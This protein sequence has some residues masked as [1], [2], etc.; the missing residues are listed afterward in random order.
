M[1]DILIVADSDDSPVESFANVCSHI[2]QFFGPGTRPSAPLRKTQTRPISV[3]VL[4]MPW[5]DVKG[6]LERLCID[7]AIDADK[8]IADNVQTFMSLIFAE[9][10]TSESRRGKAW[11]RTNLAARCARDPFVPLGEV[12]R[13]DRYHHLIPVNHSSFDRISDV[14]ASFA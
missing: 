1:R 13:E 3:T 8:T 7:A 9:R 6:H 12:F 11:L 2:E 14:L 5:T 10:W 4:M